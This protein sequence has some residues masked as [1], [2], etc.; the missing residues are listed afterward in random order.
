MTNP[1]GWC[2]ITV[3]PITGCTE[4]C[5]YCYA[6]KMAQRLAGRFGYPADDPF[7]PTFHPDV[8]DKIE[9]LAGKGKRVFLNS[10]GDWF[11]PGTNPE[12][13][14]RVISSIEYTPAHTFL[15]LTKRPDR[16]LQGLS[17][18]ERTRM[19]KDGLPLTLGGL[20]K[21]LW[22]GVSVTKQE[23]V[24]RLDSLR[25][26]L[27]NTVHKFVSFEPLHE[28]ID[29]DLRGIEW[30][31]IGAET[32]HR[33]GKILPEMTWIL[34]LVGAAQDLNI[35]VFVKDNISKETCYHFGPEYQQ[36][37]EAI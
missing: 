33:K 36:F 1:I 18:F 28:H 4:G 21:N 15:V 30:V 9:G 6:R 26:A 16:I 14:D 11:D 25:N 5:P 8:L 17:Y 7:K 34:N 23:D 12:W 27:P 22:F 20:P 3:N 31:I 13:I 10:M 37:P 2:D 19:A 35:P 29:A 24:W 32:G